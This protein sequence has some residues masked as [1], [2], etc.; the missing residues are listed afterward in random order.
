VLGAFLVEGEG[1]CEVDSSG[2]RERGGPDLSSEFEG[3][4]GEKREG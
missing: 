4:V 3:E 1:R 2:A